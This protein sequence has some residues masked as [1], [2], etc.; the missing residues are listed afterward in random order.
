MLRVFLQ[1]ILPL[2]AIISVFL[3]PI[4]LTKIEEINK[5]DDP[6]LTTHEDTVSTTDGL[7][8]STSADPSKHTTTAS[9]TT[10]TIFQ[11]IFFNLKNKH[12]FLDET[13]P[14]PFECINI[15][16]CRIIVDQNTT[17]TPTIKNNFGD[18]T[19]SKQFKLKIGVYFVEELFSKRY[20]A[21]H[22]WLQIIL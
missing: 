15:K 2:A 10:T 20:N 19:A 8:S 3:T 14:C 17:I 6:L 4:Y 22:L 13:N 5:S 1:I 12:L 16:K 7:F 18:I 21:V 11:G 9:T